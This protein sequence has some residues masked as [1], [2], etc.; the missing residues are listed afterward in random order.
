MP[1]IGSP[2]PIRRPEPAA[3]VRTDRGAVLHLQAG[4]SFL[5][6]RGEKKEEYYKENGASKVARCLMPDTLRPVPSCLLWPGGWGRGGE[7]WG[8]SR[9][10][11]GKGGRGAGASQLPPV[12]KP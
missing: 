10:K 6:K 4:D 11:K 7:G 8:C 2:L 9:L 12:M 3:V 5:S 1:P